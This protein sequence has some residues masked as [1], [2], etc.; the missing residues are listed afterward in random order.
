MQAISCF[1]SYPEELIDM[2]K[3]VP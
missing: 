2:S 1:I 3:V